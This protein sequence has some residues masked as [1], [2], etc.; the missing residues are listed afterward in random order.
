[1]YDSFKVG[2]EQ[3]DQRVILLLAMMLARDPKNLNRL[4]IFKHLCN[5]DVGNQESMIKRTD[6]EA[7]LNKAFKIALD[8]LLFFSKNSVGRK[9]T[10]KFG[11]VEH[12]QTKIKKYSE[13]CKEQALQKLFGRASEVASWQV[14]NKFCE[15][16]FLWLILS[17]DGIRQLCNHPDMVYQDPSNI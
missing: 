7:L 17:A 5:A 13:F 6:A 12:Y 1:L 9:S 8:D 2:S 15:Y 10:D 16:Q 3:L 11:R 4:S 14:D